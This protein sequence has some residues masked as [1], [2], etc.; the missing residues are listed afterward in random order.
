MGEGTLAGERTFH[1]LFP[2]GSGSR[3]NTLLQTNLCSP[4]PHRQA[5]CELSPQPPHTH[6]WKRVLSGSRSGPGSP[7]PGSAGSPGLDGS[8]RGTRTRGGELRGPG[9]L[10][11]TGDRTALVGALPRRAKLPLITE[12]RKWPH[13]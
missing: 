13:L 7:R 5:R 1:A 12:P 2:E 3:G 9:P 8:A 4:S 11:R 10:T 6:T